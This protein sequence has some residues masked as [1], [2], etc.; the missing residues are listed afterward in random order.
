MELADLRKKIDEL[1]KQ[2]LS[3]LVERM[4]VVEEV[5]DTKRQNNEEV[6]QK[7]RWQELLTS[8]SVWGVR[9]GLPEHEIKKIFEC[10][11]DMSVGRQKEIL[12][13]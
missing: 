7:N 2:L 11:H 1:D 8:R 13:H 4:K 9:A 5:A 6:I 3:I 12:G 10:I